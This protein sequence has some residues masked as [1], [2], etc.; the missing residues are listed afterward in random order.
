MGWLM[1]KDHKPTLNLTTGEIYSLPKYRS[2]IKQTEK[3]N[4]LP[5]KQPT[6]PTSVQ[7]LE[8]LRDTYG[9][10]WHLLETNLDVRDFIDKDLTL[11]DIKAIVSIA[12][13]VV[14]NN[15]STTTTKE[16]IEEHSLSKTSVNRSLT[17][18][19]SM[20]YIRD[21]STELNQVHPTVAWRGDYSVREVTKQQWLTKDNPRDYIFS[22][23]YLA[24]TKATY[25]HWETLKQPSK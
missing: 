17:R 6:P 2:H 13:G 16:I 8:K 4:N 12:E 21:I 20:G 14:H 11:A 15:Y 10:S 24:K 22:E 19:T 25:K 23:D 3:V 7:D 1:D 9:V 18:L 5:Y